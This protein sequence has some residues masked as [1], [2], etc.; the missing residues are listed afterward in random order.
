MPP[1]VTASALIEEGSAAGLASVTS[2]PEPDAARH[3]LS[4]VPIAHATSITQFGSK[5]NMFRY[6]TTAVALSE[7]NLPQVCP[8]SRY[9]RKWPG[10]TRAQAPEEAKTC[11]RLTWP[12]G[13]ASALGTIR[14]KARFQGVPGSCATGPS[15]RSVSGASRRLNQTGSHLMVG[16]HLAS[17]LT[18]AKNAAG[19]PRPATSLLAP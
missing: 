2:A 8:L 17:V 1:P 13:F 9:Q 15:Y 4:S 12:R 18:S 7:T 11:G 3:R 16:A 5:C 6:D 10:F 14:C 19:W